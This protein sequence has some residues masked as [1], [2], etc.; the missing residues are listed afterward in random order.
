MTEG[1]VTARGVMEGFK[2]EDDLQS[3]PFLSLSAAPQLPIRP[4]FA[5]RGFR[6]VPVYAGEG[7]ALNLC[8]VVVDAL[9]PYQ[10]LRC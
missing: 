8:L 7:E 5:R 4:T 6:P 2:D 10:C 1:R 3:C 9:G